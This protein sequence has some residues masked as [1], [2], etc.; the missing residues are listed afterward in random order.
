MAA[1]LVFF[2]NLIHLPGGRI[3][4]ILP[5]FIPLLQQGRCLTECLPEKGVDHDPLSF[6]PCLFAQLQQADSF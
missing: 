5:F 3:R 1:G 6:I 4:I 2:T